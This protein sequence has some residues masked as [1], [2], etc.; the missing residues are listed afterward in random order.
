MTRKTIHALVAIIVGLVLL[1]VVL[2]TGDID[3][4]PMAGQRLL[5]EFKDVANE[6]SKLRIARPAGEVGVTIRLEDKHWLISARDDYPAD[7]GKLRSLII[8]LA[9]AQVVEE[10]T[11][12]PE[13][14]PKLG[15][16]DPEEGGKGTKV[17]ISGPSFTYS[18]ILGNTAQGTRRYARIDFSHGTLTTSSR[19]GESSLLTS[20]R[21]G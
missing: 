7:L 13:H 20:L 16:D 14:Y 2:R 9:D 1:L 10:K 5:P 11:S 18:L 17:M 4:T 15:V 12:N 19:R 21:A 8:G 6:V 3:G